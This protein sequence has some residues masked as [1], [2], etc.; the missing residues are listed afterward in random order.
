MKEN[1][2]ATTRISGDLAA[3]NNVV[4]EHGT[5]LGQIATKDRNGRWIP[6]IEQDNPELQS[7]VQKAVKEAILPPP[8]PSW[9]TLR[10]Y[11][12]MSTSQYIEINGVGH[13]IGPWS[14]LMQLC[15]PP[16]RSLG[17]RGM[18]ELA[19]VGRPRI[20]FRR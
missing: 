19:L 12:R 13:N 5:T 11:N 3:V 9:G 18:R 16:G 7:Q 17:F 4:G 1:I 2:A 8:L 15:L 14:L 6:A 10:I 20:I